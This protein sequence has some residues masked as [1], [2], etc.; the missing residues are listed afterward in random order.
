[1]LDKVKGLVRIVE[2]FPVKGISYKDITP[3]IQSPEGFEAAVNLMCGDL[4]DVDF[5]VLVAPEARGFIFAAPI[6]I[7]MNKGFVP[8]RKKGKLPYKTV[9]YSYELE[10]GT[11][12]IFMHVD[13]VKPGQKVVIVDDLLAT[14]GTT[15]AVAELVK[16]LGGEVVCCSFLIELDDLGGRKRIGDIPV[17]SLVHYPH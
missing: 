7:K 10:Y 14:G 16:K 17:K 8:V 6:A 4:K 9:S 13:S 3:V 11:D 12:E 2:D 5:D 15:K 1:M